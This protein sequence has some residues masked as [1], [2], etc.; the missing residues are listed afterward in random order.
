MAARFPSPGGRGTAPASGRAATPPP[1]FS[2]L[3]ARSSFLFDSSVQSRKR[4]VRYAARARTGSRGS[5]AFRDASN[6]STARFRRTCGKPARPDGGVASDAL[7][8]F[9]GLELPRLGLD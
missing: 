5:E 3:Q 8:A 1:S 6:V 9:L 7:G 2:P 4:R